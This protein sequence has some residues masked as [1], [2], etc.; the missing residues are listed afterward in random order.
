MAVQIDRME[1]E[2]EILPAAPAAADGRGGGAPG[3]ATANPTVARD[4]IRRAV[5]GALE[6]ELAEHLRSRG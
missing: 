6:D 2:L 5:V 3:A 1:T 4:A